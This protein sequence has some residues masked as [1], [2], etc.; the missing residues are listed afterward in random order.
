MGQ[1][2]IL[3]MMLFFILVF[4]QRGSLSMDLCGFQAIEAKYGKY[5]CHYKHVMEGGG[6][7]EHYADDLRLLFRLNEVVKTYR[8]Q[9]RVRT[10]NSLESARTFMDPFVLRS[11]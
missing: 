8:Y 10:I 3:D 11:L 6:A 7:F 1:N 5:G 2:S 4:I 9:Q